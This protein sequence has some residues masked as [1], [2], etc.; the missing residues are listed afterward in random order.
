MRFLHTTNISTLLGNTGD[1]FFAY[2]KQKRLI[3]PFK[4]GWLDLKLAAIF[5]GQ[6]ILVTETETENLL[7]S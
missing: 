5:D 3:Q 6:N 1:F 2:S 4:A 7:G